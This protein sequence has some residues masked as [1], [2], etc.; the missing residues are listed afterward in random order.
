M[1]YSLHTVIER[2]EADLRALRE[3][4]TRLGNTARLLGAGASLDRELALRV[5]IG[6]I[7]DAALAD[8]ASWLRHPSSQIL[9]E[10][11]RFESEFVQ[12]ACE[13]LLEL[14][15]VERLRRDA[16]LCEAERSSLGDIWVESVACYDA[17]CRTLLEEVERLRG[18]R[19][20]GR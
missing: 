18:T 5:L 13:A 9:R 12:P 4:I 15:D 19:R 10:L 14:R 3:E 16:S 6:E 20:R 2:D 1:T 7:L 11:A 8:P 17:A